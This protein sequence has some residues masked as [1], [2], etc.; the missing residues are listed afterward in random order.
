M[1]QDR[2]A[3]PGFRLWGGATVESAHDHRCAMSFAVLAQVASSPVKINDAQYI[4]TSYPGF[5]D[6]LGALG[7]SLQ[8]VESE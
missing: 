8:M 7:A 5:V 6:D 3:P 1:N 4:A 2:A